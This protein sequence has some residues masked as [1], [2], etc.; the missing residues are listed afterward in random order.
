M[1]RTVDGQDL[2][3]VPIEERKC[4][5]ANLLRRQRDGIAFT[6]HYAGDGAIIYKRYRGEALGLAVPL[7]PR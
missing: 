3:R 5:L 1:G 4:A 6:E 2:R 7:R